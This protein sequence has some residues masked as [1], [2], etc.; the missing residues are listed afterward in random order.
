MKMKICLAYQCCEVC[1]FPEFSPSI[2]VNLMC[3]QDLIDNKNYSKDCCELLFGQVIHHNPDGGLDPEAHEKPIKT[4]IAA[5]RVQ[6][7]DGYDD[8]DF[9]VR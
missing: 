2:L 1:E 8:K 7:P 4:T 3:H 6:F 9:G 5:L